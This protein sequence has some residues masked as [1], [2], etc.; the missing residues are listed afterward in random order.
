MI[1]NKFTP[2]AEETKA[3][4]PKVQAVID[5]LKKDE[6]LPR[7]N[8]D[9]KALKTKASEIAECLVHEPCAKIFIRQSTIVYKK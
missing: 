6:P 9:I 4:I 7:L 1:T 5:N 3:L 8:D 2:W